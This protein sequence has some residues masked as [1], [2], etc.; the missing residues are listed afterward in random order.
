MKKEYTNPIIEIIEFTN[1]DIFTSSTVSFDPDGILSD[2]EY[3]N[4]F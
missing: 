3:D 2:G 1:E 4:W